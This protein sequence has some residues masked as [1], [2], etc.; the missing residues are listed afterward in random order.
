MTVDKWGLDYPAARVVDVH[1]TVAGSVF[2]DPYRWLEEDDEETAAW[3]EAQTALA[4][5]FVRDWPHFDRLRALVDH[6]VADG[7][8]SPNWM[9]DP[10][11]QFAGGRWF[12][13]D[14]IADPGYQDRAVATVSESA[15]GAGRVIYDP[16]TQNGQQITWFVPS[17]NGRVVALGVASNG[18]E[19]AEIQLFDVDTGDRLPDRIP[20][21]TV[22]PLVTPQWI[23]DSSGFFYTAGDPSAEVFSFDVYFHEVGKPPVTAPEPVSAPDAPVV[24]VAADGR[25]AVA[26]SVWALPRFVC[27]LPQRNWRPFVREVDASV[28]GLI[29]GD[30]YVA[31]TNH[32]AARGRLVAIPL[33]SATPE[34]PN[35]W[36][37]LVPGSD[38]V[39]NQVRLIGG[40]LVVIG[41]VDA[42]ARAW[43]FDKEGRQLEEVPLPGAGAMQHDILPQ[44]SLVP[45]GHPDEFVFLFSTLTSSPGLYRYRLG[46]GRLETVREPLVTVPD[47]SVELGW[48]ASADGTRVPFHLVLPANGR[49]GPLPTLIT[50]YGGGRVSWPA[51]Y[52]GPLAAFVASGGALVV[53]HQRGGND[54]GSV[55]ADEGRLAN[56]QTSYDDLYAIAE[57]VISRGVTTPDHLAMTG[58]S[59]GGVTAGVALTQRPDLWAAVIA[60][61]PILDI[62]GTHRHPYGRFAVASD[63]GDL[64]DPDDVRRLAKISP[65]HL[66][67]D[68]VAYPWFYVHAGAV[69]MACPPGP[70]RKFMARFQNATGSSVPAL[71]RVWDDVG[72]GT[73]SSRSEGVLHTSYWLAF[74]MRRFDMEPA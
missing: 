36:H 14:R 68:G 54:L 6:H 35:T 20:Q 31:V 26:S 23:G 63:Y 9:V 72:H 45:A 43:V 56:K 3:Q 1:D 69:D 51:Q 42:E 65:Y 27:E 44:A 41:S 32:G 71:L 2:P 37:E 60:Q 46:T 25:H 64:G 74:L 39:L 15:A 62:I 10:P 17:P 21:M 18:L 67:E 7:T 50:A 16:N 57:E 66:V 5:A 47:A 55:W 24:Q 33:D 13:L 19:M 40:R 22:G 52:P 28:C 73:S 48:A 4:D 59:S 53:S 70:N 49:S 38:R 12:R 8:G 11:V 29:D 30:R 34:D 61:C 58:W